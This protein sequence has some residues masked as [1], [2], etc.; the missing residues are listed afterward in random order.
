[1]YG[2]H[3][4]VTKTR[5]RVQ[6]IFWWPE[7]QGSIKSYIKSCKICQ[8]SKAPA[9][10]PTYML[11]PLEVPNGNCKVVIMDFIFGLTPSIHAYDA[12]FVCG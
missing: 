8:W 1:M 12:I 6:I 2:G 4:A 11:Q 3:V 9:L 7:M 5:K 10:K